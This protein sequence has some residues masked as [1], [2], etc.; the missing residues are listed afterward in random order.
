MEKS[1]PVQTQKV[2]ELLAQVIVADGHVLESEIMAFTECT[3]LIPLYDLDGV[4]LTETFAK[5]WFQQHSEKI[6]RFR[7]DDNSDIEL[8]RLILSLAEF[9]AKQHVVDALQKISRSDGHE[10]ME[11]KLLISIVKAYWQHD[12]LDAPGSRIE[13]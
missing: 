2:L 1:I 3:A 5:S 9:P 6:S 10:H 13:V 8:T 12:G 4:Q 11:E 7:D